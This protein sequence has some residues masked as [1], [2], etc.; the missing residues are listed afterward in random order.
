MASVS[1]VSLLLA[2][3]V[4][5]I[6]K[7][8]SVSDGVNCLSNLRQI[9]F[10]FMLYST[11]NGNRLPA[12]GEIGTPW[13]YSLRRYL[14]NPKLYTC[15]SDQELGPVIG[16][17]FDWRD[18]GVTT[19]TLAGKPLYGPYRPHLALAFEALPGWHLPGKINVARLDMSVEPMKS[20]EFF[21]D[22]D[23]PIARSQQ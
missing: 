19:T 9:G 20:D 8:R 15:P 7:A 17:S 21:N 2:M 18:T 6:M 12:P 5:T 14:P 10:G 16:S 13:E 22:L 1:I 11:D 23:T 3:L 4:P